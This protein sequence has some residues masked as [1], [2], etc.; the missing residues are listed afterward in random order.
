MANVPRLGDAVVVS[1]YDDG[2]PIAGGWITE[3]RTSTVR[4]RLTT[5]GWTERGYAYLT[6]ASARDL[7]T[8]Q[9]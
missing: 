1:R 5:G 4:V 3:L 2:E 6:R 7:T 8:L 9:H